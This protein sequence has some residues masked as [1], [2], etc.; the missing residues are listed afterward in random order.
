MAQEPRKVLIRSPNWI[1]DQVLAYPFFYFLR[2][3]YPSAHITAICAPWVEDVQFRDL[4]DE[5]KTLPRIFTGKLTEKLGALEKAAKELKEQGP[6]DLAISLPNSF[7][8]AWLL[9]RAGA[10]R[11]R[12]YRADGRGWLLDESLAWD[13]APTRHRAQA[14]LDLL[15]EDA[16]PTRDVRE[17]WGVL[18]EDE[19]DEPIPGELERF[20]FERSWPTEEYVE[21]PEGPYWVLAPGAT[22]VSRRWPVEYW[23]GLARRIADQTGWSGVIVGSPKEAPIAT[24]LCHDR[25]LKLLDRTAQGPIPG[26]ARLFA[27]AMITVTNESGLAHVAALCGSRVQIVCGAADPR[28]TRPLGPGQVQVSFNPVECWPCERNTCSQEGSAYL[29]CLKGIQADQVWEEIR[30]ERKPPA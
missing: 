10:R 30:R 14:Y 18:P 27:G 12:G 8:A 23:M 20:A 5:V 7:S 21:A 29:Q 19:L 13:P 16:R 22:A 15:P 24:E 3:R 28:R 26:L 17:F 1:G 11:R 25:S 9:F 6:W 4:V 2:K